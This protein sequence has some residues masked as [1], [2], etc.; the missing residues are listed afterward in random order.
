MTWCLSWWTP[1]GAGEVLVVVAFW[2]G[3]AATGLW[4]WRRL[5]SIRV[6][7]LTAD[8]DGDRYQAGTGTEE[9]PDPGARSGSTR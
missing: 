2:A 6:E 4:A 7:T 5:R 3:V 9:A 8:S 1:S